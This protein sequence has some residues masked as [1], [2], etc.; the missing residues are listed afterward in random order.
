[1]IEQRKR[2]DSIDALRGLS[3]VLMVIH[4]FLLDL[5]QLCGAPYWLFSNWLFDLLHYI[6]AGT[7]VFLAGVSSNF[8]RNN[9]NRGVKCFAIAMVMTYVTGLSVIDEPIRFGVL[10]LLGF[11]MVFYGMTK[12]YLDR[13]PRSLQPVIFTA[14]L[15]LTSVYFRD[16]RVV[17]ASGFLGETANYLYIF[18]WMYP[19]FYSADYFPIFPWIFVFLLGTWAGW[20][21]A[22]RRLPEK[23]YTF[24]CPI[25]PSIGRSS[26]LIYVAHQ[27]I[28]YGLIFFVKAVL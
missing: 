1:M 23:F 9:V 5:T 18:G 6:F 28:L 13:I 27:P 22:E 20:Y 2:I 14:L 16:T 24:T 25:L 10:H 8:S 4:H 26:L 19:G 3:V 17:S 12:K 21:V 15:V 11:C 7:F